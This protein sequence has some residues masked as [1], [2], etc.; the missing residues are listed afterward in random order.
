VRPHEFAVL[1]ILVTMGA[2]VALAIRC[3]TRSFV[4]AALLT[5]LVVCSGVQVYLARQGYDWRRDKFAL[6]VVLYP[7]GVSFA[8]AGAVHVALHM[9]HYRRSAGRQVDPSKRADRP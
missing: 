1:V 9:W 6:L 5:V 4:R 7:A 3:V 8:A 2:V